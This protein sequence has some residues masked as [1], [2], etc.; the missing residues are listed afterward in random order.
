[1]SE[2]H[3][4]VQGATCECQH[5]FTPDMLKVSSHSYE[6]ANDKDGSQKL[7]AS[8]LEI[9]QPFQ[10]NTFGQ[11]KLQPTGSSYKPCQPMITEWTGF[12]EDA[13]LKN[14]GNI[15]L[16]DSKATCAIAGAPCVKI[17]NHGQIAEPSS[18]NMKNAD[19]DTQ[20]QLNPMVNTNDIDNSTNTE[21]SGIVENTK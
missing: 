10:A 16:E 6:Y 4:V 19:E 15:I 11:C 12:Y 7:I 13:T 18:Q 3:I 8:T 17:T 9:G 21:N 5:G 14:G 20:A 2:K 1:M